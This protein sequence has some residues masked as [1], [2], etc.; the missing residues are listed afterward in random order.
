MTSRNTSI[1]HLQ[2]YP[3]LSGY[4]LTKEASTWVDAHQQCLEMGL[5]LATPK[6]LDERN[7]LQ[8]FLDNYRTGPHLS[9]S[10]S[11]HYF[12]TWVGGFQRGDAAKSDKGWVWLDG[13]VVKGGWR[14]DEPST[15]LYPPPSY[16]DYSYGPDV[17]LPFS[18]YHTDEDG[19]DDDKPK[20]SSRV[21]LGREDCLGLHRDYCFGDCPISWRSMDCARVI[22]GVCQ[23]GEYRTWCG[24][25]VQSSRKIWMAVL[26]RWL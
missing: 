25:C 16:Y 15:E 26:S 7:H 21:E 23:A 13:A 19:K 14:W 10:A 1:T 3:A 9:H 18:Q 17:P 20:H 2:T 12:D 6:T 22:H 24:W 4:T 5:T 8:E 11:L